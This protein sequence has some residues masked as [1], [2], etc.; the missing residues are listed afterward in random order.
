MFPRLANLL[1]FNGELPLAARM[2]LGL[3]TDETVMV[4]DT[5]ETDIL[6]GVQM[7]Y[8][9]V[10]VLT[11]GTDTT[12]FRRFAYQP[13]RVVDSIADLL[14]LRERPAPARAASG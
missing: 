4:G 9:T 10:L 6:G 14:P 5:M 8:E 13:D 2:V 11:G 12:S 7:G 3:T 1:R